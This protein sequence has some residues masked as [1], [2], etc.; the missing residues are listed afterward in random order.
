MLFNDD[1]TQ[2]LADWSDGD[3]T[4]LERLTPLI[5][6]EL[7]RRAAA[8][9]HRESDADTLQATALVHEAYV[10]VLG[11]R[12]L[13]WQS[14]AHFINT[15]AMLMRRILVDHARE[16][17]AKKRGS[18]ER[19]VTLS[20]AGAAA[21]GEDLDLV[22]LNDALNRL[23]TDHPRQAQVVELKFFGGLSAQ[24]IVDVMKPGRGHMSLRTVE[25]DW[26]FA[27]TWL[28]REMRTA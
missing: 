24:E 12:N 6:D 2:M 22:D 17:K 23:A 3:E 4:A 16:R 19:D 20:R 28:H 18:G 27:K 14:R 8:Y 26:T 13:E 10:Q 15:I 11:L 9:L 21:T 25:R 7:R 5:Y 1:L